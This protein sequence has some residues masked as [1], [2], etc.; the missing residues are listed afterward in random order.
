M[1]SG[2]IGS[3]AKRGLRRGYQEGSTAWA[4][5]GVAMTGLSIIRW[6]RAKDKAAQVVAV[7]RLQAGE[8]IVIRALA[9]GS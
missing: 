8:S 6:L 4:V 5:L 7:E 1:F 3:L 2:L 9:P